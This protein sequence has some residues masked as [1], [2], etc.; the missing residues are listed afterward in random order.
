M[1]IYWDN[2]KENGNY[3]DW[4]YLAVLLKVKLCSLPLHSNW[5]FKHHRPKFDLDPD[6]FQDKSPHAHLRMGSYARKGNPILHEESM[7]LGSL[8][9]YSQFFEVLEWFWLLGFSGL[10]VLGQLELQS[11]TEAQDPQPHAAP[12]TDTLHHKPLGVI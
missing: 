10:G 12:T 6:T 7:A 5:V 11:N 9:F 1:G 2:G 4:L 3:S 8:C